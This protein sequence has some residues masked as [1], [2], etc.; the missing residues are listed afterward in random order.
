MIRQIQK[1]IE[2]LLQQ[3]LKDLY[4]L[5]N[6]PIPEAQYPPR[7]MGDLSY[8]LVFPLAK[9]LRKNPNQIAQEIVEELRKHPVPEITRIEIGGNGYLNFFLNRE[10]IAREILSTRIIPE[11]LR[12]GKAIVE[13][14]NINPN[15]AA[16][17]GHLR[18]ACLGDTLVRL[19]EFM[20]TKVEVQN[21]IDDTGVQVADVVLGFQRQGKTAKDLDNIPG[22]IDYFFWDLYA[23]THKFLEESP[24]NKTLR[25][26]ILRDME[27]RVEPVFSL[28][29]QIADRIIRCHLATMSRL[30]IDYELLPRESD[31]LG[32]HFWEKTFR[33]LK[34]KGVVTRI[35]EGKNKGCW[36]MRLSGSE[37][38]E[39]MQNPDKILVRSNGIVTYAGKDIAYQLWKFGLLGEDFHYRMFDRKPDGHV[40]WTTSTTPAESDHPQF[41]GAD[42]VYN[43]IDQRQSYLQKVVAEGLRALGYKK[44]A[45]NSIHFSYEMVTLSPKSA[46]EL[47]FEL[48]S[49][50]Q[51]KNFVE[52]SGRRGL[53]VKADDLL[54]RLEDKARNRI[55][56]LYPDLEPQQLGTLAAEIAAGALRYFMIRY[57]RNTLITFDL[58]E[59]L[60]F[61]G[62]TGPYLQYAL[63]RARNI[64]KKLDAAGF[65]AA[66]HPPEEFANTF[67]LLQDTQ[68][69]ESNDS[70][71]LLL[72]LIKTKDI[73][74]RALRSLELSYFAKHVFEMA[75]L[76]NNYY[77]KYPVLH[78]S[79]VPRKLLRIAIV[80]MFINGMQSSLDLIG[81]PVPSKM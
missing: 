1:T 61:E 55:S 53:G 62:E 65:D 57:T 28:S 70:W 63:V 11:S 42:L 32:L 17:V 30:G 51:E 38:F 3:A 8:T 39:D 31:I 27:Q 18:N 29:Q 15:K 72:A 50:E 6:Y 33:L 16:H 36:V 59:V 80:R 44:Q 10:A 43:V 73:I 19:L 75:Q 60:S 78:E 4:G 40:I 47:G 68:D 52:M 21:Y 48:T 23:E 66:S 74:N 58:D 37:E 76:F 79:D 46:R 71:A 77:H 69:P 24:E 54:D 5:E 22:R 35:E 56:P 2:S 9:T 81:I 13:H 49:E 7:E 26:Q 41:G 25:E 34:E 14:T 67:R 64:L 45:E 20:G 12:Q